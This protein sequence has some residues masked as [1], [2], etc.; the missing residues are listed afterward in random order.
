MCRINYA[1]S[2]TDARKLLGGCVESGG[3]NDHQCEGYH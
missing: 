3:E 2:G 1:V